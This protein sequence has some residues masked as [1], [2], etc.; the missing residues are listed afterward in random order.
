[1]EDFV[2]SLA[3]ILM[4]KVFF[5]FSGSS[6]SKLALSLQALDHLSL[7]SAKLIYTPKPCETPIRLDEFLEMDLSLFSFPP[8][9]SKER[10]SE[11]SKIEDGFARFA[12]RFPRSFSVL[13]YMGLRLSRLPRAR[14][15]F[16][17]E[18]FTDRRPVVAPGSGKLYSGRRWPTTQTSYK[19]QCEGSSG[20]FTWSMS[21]SAERRI[22]EKHGEMC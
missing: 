10:A 5:A 22:W 1:M 9:S 15:R 13:P 20:K 19:R 17:R 12:F 2:R 16:V 6:E 4:F 3:K 11:I 18:N 21:E 7:S 8:K 14:R